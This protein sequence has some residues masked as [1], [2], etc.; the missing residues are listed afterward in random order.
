VHLSVDPSQAYGYGGPDNTYNPVPLRE[1]DVSLFHAVSRRLRTANRVWEM[2]VKG[3]SMTLA[4]A[5]ATYGR[6][7]YSG[8][9][10][11]GK[12]TEMFVD[13]DGDG[14]LDYHLVDSTD[15][16]SPDQRLLPSQR[17]PLIDMRRPDEVTL[18]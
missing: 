10:L 5:R 11:G 15:P 16:E 3:T 14:M 9:L 13:Y 7:S 17:Q 2:K 12:V 6:G 1:N 8:L 4:L 18:S